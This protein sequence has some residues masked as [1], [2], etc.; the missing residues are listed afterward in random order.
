MRALR[1]HAV[2]RAAAARERYGPVIDWSTFLE[3]L[4]DPAVTR[5]PTTV[6]FDAAPLERGEFAHVEPAGDTPSQGFRLFVHPRLREREDV[7]P[8]AAAYHVVRV[9]YGDVATRVE[10]ELF[11]ATLLGLDV[12]RY[13]ESL[14]S[15][16]DELAEEE[17]RP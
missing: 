8:L 12:D 10:A 7:L 9:N 5:F 4:E 3:L 11:G 16:S 2:E 15:L 1:D 13:Y 6:E 14:V 17:D